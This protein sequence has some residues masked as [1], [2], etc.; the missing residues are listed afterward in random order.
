MTWHRI[1]DEKLQY[2]SCTVRTIYLRT[3]GSHGLLKP[4]VF[5]VIVDLSE[6]V[7]PPLFSLLTQESRVG[8]HLMIDRH[9]FV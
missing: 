8:S 2:E 9:I 7:P 3:G 5:A 1:N 4:Y 6:S